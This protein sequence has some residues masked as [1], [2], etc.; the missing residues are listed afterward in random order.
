MEKFH[1]FIASRIFWIFCAR[2]YYT[3][4]HL[5]FLKPAIGEDSYRRLQR[6]RDVALCIFSRCCCRMALLGEKWLRCSQHISAISA[7]SEHTVYKTVYRDITSAVRYGPYTTP[8]WANIALT[9]QYG[10]DTVPFTP[11]GVLLISALDL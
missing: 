2:Y 10:V 8:H 9:V 5:P 3:I 4:I 7:K 6:P 1:L 11:L